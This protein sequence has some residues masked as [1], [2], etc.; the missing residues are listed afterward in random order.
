M[1]AL[2]Y[3]GSQWELFQD[4]ETRFVR[5]L[6]RVVLTF[7]VL[8]LIVPWLPVVKQD[9]EKQAEVPPRVAKLLMQKRELPPTPPKP[10]VQQA[11]QEPEKN[12]AKKAPQKKRATQTKPKPK[13][14]PNKQA[15]R[16]KVSK[17]GLLALRDELTELQSLSKIDVVQSNK[18][19]K[20]VEAVKPK[21]VV[22]AKS[23]NLTQGSGGIDTRKLT[24]A[25]GDSQLADR[26]LTQVDAP[27]VA[28]GDVLTQGDETRR[29]RS[30]EDVRLV[31][32]QAKAR[33]QNLYERQL[34]KTPGIRGKVV[35]EIRIL[36][37][38]KVSS[39]KILQ[40]D[41]NTEDLE[42][43]FIMRLRSLDFGAEDVEPI[44]YTYPLDFL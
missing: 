11:K 13:A 3:S 4:E 31:L 12:Q 42:R 35:F 43:K 40:S 15:V 24:R 6:K 38:G 23:N 18:Q 21:Q 41:L 33:L 27:L 1:M 39:V 29:I 36:P 19:L 8:G 22:I 37:S 20:K 7:L 25:V 44:I 2:T 26:S 16:E 9:R 5:I 10:K 28:G 30:E 17:V 34:R 14:E 32:H